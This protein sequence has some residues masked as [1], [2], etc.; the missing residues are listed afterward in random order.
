M[1]DLKE[2]ASQAMGIPVALVERSAAARATE[3]D[4]D[5]DTI[6]AA[7][8]GGEAAPPAPEPAAEEPEPEPAAD[9]TGPEQEEVPAPT[10]VAVMDA[11]EP[12][13]ATQ[14]PAYEPEPEPELE[15]VPLGTRLRT[16]VRVGA[17]TGAALGLFAFL[18]ASAIW[19][20]N[21]AYLEDSG[22]IVQVGS[23][24]VLV[25]VALVSVVFGAIVASFSRAAAGWRNPAM[26]LSSSKSSTA[27]L[28]A[29]TGLVLGLIAG[30]TLTAGVA[31][32]IE[33]S[34]GIIQLP[35]FATLAVMLIGGA[36]LGALTA[37]IPQLLGTPI[38]IDETSEDEVEVVKRRLGGAMSIPIAA[39]V[40][41]A[42]LVV[43]LG[44]LFL[45]SNHLGTNGAAIVAI[46]TAAGILGFSSLAGSRPEMRISMGEMLV[47]VAG[48]ATVLL[49][50]LAVLFY[51]GQDDHSEEEA[52]EEAAVVL[53]LS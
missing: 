31:T 42:V 15:P 38:A 18:M 1:S 25:G 49:I 2:A 6:L 41:L 46:L 10:A 3:N 44:Y 16:A 22:P 29:V 37:A 20:P 52:G 8:A 21:S 28:G 23:T 53:V 12:A 32:P 45:Q 9:E 33:D 14:A 47:A 24:G 34:E 4:S 26:Q 35:V 50:I 40:I 27:W 11:P 30:A 5:V 36:L 39:A 19:A 48:I 43:P 13:P 7:W 17:W 51:T